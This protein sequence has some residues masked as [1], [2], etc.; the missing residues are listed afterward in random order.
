M[1]KE[2]KQVCVAGTEGGFLLKC[3]TASATR[4]DPKRKGN[5]KRKNIVLC[6]YFVNIFMHN[7]D[8]LLNNPVNF[9]YS[10]YHTGPVLSVSCSPFHRNLFLSSG[11]DGQIRLYNMLMVKSE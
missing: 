9:T 2:N 7:L 10:S 8:V 4:I 3:G 1:T 11:S 6:D 5:Q